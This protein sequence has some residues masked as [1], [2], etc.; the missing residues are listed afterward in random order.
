MEEIIGCCF[1]RLTVVNSEGQSCNCLCSCGNRMTTTRWKLIGGHT[2]SCGCLRSELSA[3]RLRTHGRSKTPVWY[4]WQGMHSRCRDPGNT[5]YTRYGA[6]GVSV[7]ER[8]G[9]FENFIRDI[10]E[11]PEGMTLERRDSSKGYSPDNCYWATHKQQALSRRTTRWVT[12]DGKTL[13]LKDWA[14]M[15][16]MPYL[17]LYKRHVVRGLPFTEAIK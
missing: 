9:S 10:G 5:S 11:R 6:A 3:E 17:K 8:W 13:C 16:G 15:L 14:E 1:G 12:H 4:V 2:K 7:C